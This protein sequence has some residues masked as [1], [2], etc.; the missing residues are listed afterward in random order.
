MAIVRVEQFYPFPQNQLRKVVQ[1]YAN[2]KEW[3]WVQ[4]EPQNM[5]AW[6]FMSN[7]LEMIL[8]QKIDYVGRPASSS[9]ATGISKI[10][11]Q[12]QNEIIEKSFG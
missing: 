6:N 3:V 4:E 9:V 2:V 7:Q 11:Y 1:Q 12:Q 10:H 8:H 5:G